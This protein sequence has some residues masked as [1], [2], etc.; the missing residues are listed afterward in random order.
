MQDHQSTTARWHD[1]ETK[2]AG[3]VAVAAILAFATYFIYFGARKFALGDP[4]SWGDFGDYFGG[5][6]NPVIGIITVILVVRTLQAT[7]AEAD[8][9][10]EEMKVQTA[11]FTAQLEHYGREQNLAELQKRLD[12]AL[13][14][15]NLAVSKE[16]EHLEL[17]LLGENVRA[18]PIRIDAVLGRAALVSHLESLKLKPNWNAINGCWTTLLDE[19]ANLLREMGEYCV[20]Y[21]SVAGNRILSDFYRRRVNLAMRILDAAG[22]VSAKTRQQLAV[23]RLIF[24]ETQ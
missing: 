14:A 15:W 22:L 16:H 20:D 4:D 10:R 21:D 7:R 5:I 6:V 8:L 9:T 3:W 12:G 18:T 11:L 17:M 13:S 1:Q 23:G 19:C 24:A 2:L